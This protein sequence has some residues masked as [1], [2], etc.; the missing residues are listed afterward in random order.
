VQ[1]KRRLHVSH[2]NKLKPGSDTDE[3]AG[4]A[5]TKKGRG[6]RYYHF[7][8]SLES[9]RK[10]KQKIERDFLVGRIN[11]PF[12]HFCLDSCHVSAFDLSVFLGRFLAFFRASIKQCVNASLQ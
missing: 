7:L 6:Y 11:S 8:L 2:V 12:W 3:S 10:V 5:G 9:E 1:A 4:L